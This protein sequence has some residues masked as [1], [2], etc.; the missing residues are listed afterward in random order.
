[1]S[2]QLKRK[3]FM[4]ISVDHHRRRYKCDP[5]Q[6]TS[7]AI[8]LDFDGPQPNHFGTEKAKQEV[9]KLGTF[10]G[11]TAKGG[12]CNVNTLTMIPHCNGTH[13]ETVSHIV[14]EDIWVS[15]CSIAP[16]MVAMLCSVQPKSVSQLSD[17]E[18]KE[19]YRPVL[20]DEDQVVT[21]AM[22]LHSLNA[23]KLDLI[24]PHALLV[25]TLPNDA[26][27]TSRAYGEKFSPAFFTIEAMRMI[28]ETNV[29]HLL[30]DLPSVDRMYDDGLLTN[31]HL[32]WN[33]KEQEHRMDSDSH[34]DKT[35]TEMIF[36]D[37]EVS[38]GVY[39]L[40]LQVPALASDAAPSRPVLFPCTHEPLQ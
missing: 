11:D 18:K 17:A 38:D 39:L 12:S 32:F 7:V 25:R 30:V 26:A 20:N 4:K 28:N 31:H 6:S 13:T 9:L 5:T 24:R 35:I 37:N 21:R 22:L 10:V 19:S 23:E 1:M 2:P 27:K 16:L 34:Q 36:V 33:V 8:T 3:R 40:S 14:N 29:R 15:H